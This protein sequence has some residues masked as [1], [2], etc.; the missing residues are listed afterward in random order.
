M[1]KYTFEF[2]ENLYAIDMSNYINNEINLPTG[3]THEVIVDLL[4]HQS[5]TDFD[6]G[7][8]DQ[9]CQSCLNG[10]AEKAKYFKFLEYYFYAFTKNG[11][12]VMSN[13]S[14]EY[15]NTSF[16]KMLKKGV[17]DNSYII[18]VIVCIECGKYSIE[19]EECES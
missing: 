1:G 2:D 17:V 5:N 15:K 18:S 12:Y 14:E 6:I 11:K 8:Y 9:A 3:L 13:I 19:I 16:K 7:Y 10:V 4:K